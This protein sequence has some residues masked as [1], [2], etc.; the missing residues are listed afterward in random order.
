[1]ALSKLISD[2]VYIM[3]YNKFV[4]RLKRNSTM[5]VDNYV[6]TCLI[7]EYAS[8]DLHNGYSLD[9]SSLSKNEIAH[10]FDRLMDDD[11]AVR[12]FVLDHMQKIVDER[13]CQMEREDRSKMGMSFSRKSNGDYELL[14]GEGQS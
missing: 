7:N 12:N 3:Q 9:V 14:C 13:L 4:V 11:S 1:M 6:D 2:E 8:K 10:F 5:D